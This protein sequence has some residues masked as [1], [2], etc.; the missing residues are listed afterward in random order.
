MSNITL[1]KRLLAGMVLF[2]CLVCV[3]FIHFTHL[4]P[5]Y[6]D[7]VGYWVYLPGFFIHGNMTI[8]GLSDAFRTMVTTVEYNHWGHMYWELHNGTNPYA[9]GTSLMQIPFFLVAHLYASLSSHVSDGFSQ[10]YQIASQ[11][12]KIF[13]ANIG[14]VF[15]FLSLRHLKFSFIISILSTLLISLSTGLIL[16]TATGGNFSHVFSFAAVAMF[17]FFTLR[18]HNSVGIRYQIVVGLLL[19]LVALVRSTNI[20]V[21]LIYI[22][23]G[24]VT[25]G[26]VIKRLKDKDLYMKFASAFVAFLAVFSIQLFYWNATYGSFITNPYGNTSL[27]FSWTSPHIYNGL[28]SLTRGL[29]VWHPVFLFMVPGLFMLHKIVE[30]KKIQ[31]GLVLFVILFVYITFAWNMWW[32]GWSFGQRTFNGV[33]P[34]LSI[35]FATFFH[36][37][38]VFELDG[39]NRKQLRYAKIIILFTLSLLTVRNISF[40]SSVRNGTFRVMSEGYSLSDFLFIVSAGENQ[41]LDDRVDSLSWFDSNHYIIAE[42]HSPTVIA[43]FHGINFATGFDGENIHGFSLSGDGRALYN[44]LEILNRADMQINEFQLHEVFTRNIWFDGSR[45]YRKNFKGNFDIINEE[46]IIQLEHGVK[47]IVN[48][49]GL[50]QISPE[51]YAQLGTNFTIDG[52]LFSSSLIVENDTVWLVVN[53][54]RTVIMQQ[55]RFNIWI[56]YTKR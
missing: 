21:G 50:V 34:I 27:Q 12:S 10:P 44:G 40:A 8:T 47:D 13:Y 16:Y 4:Q 5:I 31:L 1:E 42:A 41:S 36:Q 45:I 20:L 19:G 17:L 51:R 9:I 6:S 33:L 43:S 18:A 35:P 48:S 22:L 24:V 55:A 46:E 32:Y 15:T 39:K 52:D 14:L 30:L 49:G 29:F 26:D 11:V 3:L 7:G 38:Q 28:F 54:S 25:V 2:N 23:Y 53:A 56:E 37:L